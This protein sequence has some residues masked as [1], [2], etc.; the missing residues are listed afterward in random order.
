M[1]K[2]RENPL[3]PKY[4][5]IYGYIYDVKTGALVEVPAATDPDYADDSPAYASI[6]KL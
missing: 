3:V 5:P 1:R 4:I 2:I 6:K